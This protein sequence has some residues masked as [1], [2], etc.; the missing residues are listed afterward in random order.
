[1][2]IRPA[3]PRDMAALSARDAAQAVAAAIQ[4]VYPFVSASQAREAADAVLDALRARDIGLYRDA[5][6]KPASD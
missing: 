1:M 3:S 5:E 6:A 2:T 4:T